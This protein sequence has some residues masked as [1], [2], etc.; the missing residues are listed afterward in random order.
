[1]KFGYKVNHNGTYYSS[2]DEVPVDEVEAEIGSESDFTEELPFSDTEIEMDG[3]PARRG[4]PRKPD[5]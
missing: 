1:M 2:G 4:K 5:L 3:E